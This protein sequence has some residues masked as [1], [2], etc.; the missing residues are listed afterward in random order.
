M[1]FTPTARLTTN[2]RMTVARTIL[3]DGEFVDT[4]YEHK[5]TLF[6]IMKPEEKSK[7][8]DFMLDNFYT[9]AIVP[10]AIKLRDTWPKFE[11]LNDEMDLMLDSPACVVTTN[12]KEEIVGAVINTIW[13]TDPDYETFPVD[14][15][16]WLNLS[17][18]IAM[19]TTKD[20]LYRAVIWRNYQ[21]MLIYHLTQSLAQKHGCAYYLYGGMGYTK[22]EYRSRGGTPLFMSFCN[23]WAESKNTLFFNTAT[24]PGFMTMIERNLPGMFVTLANMPYNKLTFRLQDDDFSAFSALEE[25]MVL[26]A[27]NR[28]SA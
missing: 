27:S 4:T 17:G 6:R 2:G 22:P 7:V 24:Y 21:F 11:Y 28:I 1:Y 3:K 10:S 23:D 12:V 8:K 18:D 25:G 19:E 14:P 26:M 5:D 16:E 13:L 9:N 20:P 15:V